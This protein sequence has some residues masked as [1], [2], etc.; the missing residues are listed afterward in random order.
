MKK[1]TKQQKRL[2]KRR[3][4]SSYT[5]TLI[6]ISLV[7]FL[8]SLVGLLLFNQHKVTNHIKENVGFTIFLKKDIKQVDMHKLRKR[9]DAMDIVKSSEFV[10]QEEASMRLAETLGKEYVDLAEN[11]SVPPSI[12]VRFFAE[13]ATAE[14]FSEIENMMKDNAMVDTIHYDRMQVAKL[15]ANIRKIS[16]LLLGFSFL[17]LIISVVLINN[18][19]RLSIYSKR[20]IINTMQLVG[21]T[22]N[23]I[24]S[25]FL[26]HGAFN[27]FYSGTIALAMLA[28]LLYFLQNEIKEITNYLDF[29]LLGVLFLSVILIGIFLSLVA[30]FFAVNKFLNINKDDL[31]I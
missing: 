5:S 24:R 6:S 8:L 18:T 14:S 2:I 30:T 10:S 4:L 22:R 21:A 12:E 1:Q 31:Y 11:H 17:L 13:Y 15:N 28:G 25:P 19:I 7:L 27:G 9:I 26:L 3:L 23:Y 29:E 16:M 20:F